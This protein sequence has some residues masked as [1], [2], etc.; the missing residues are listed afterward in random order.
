[1]SVSLL[2]VNVLVALLWTNHE[3]HQAARDWYKSH[4]RAGWATCP[5]TQAGFVRVSS[6]PRVVADAPLPAK[7][8]EILKAN[9]NDPTHHFWKD[10]IPFVDAVALFRDRFTGHQQTADAYLFGLAIHKRGILVTF[11]TSIA[12]LAPEG[13]SYL[14]SL[15]FIGT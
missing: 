10:E 6:N 4:Q 14:K 8:I 2:D 7:A 5:L 3:H 11:D 9:L 12:A 13:S 1:V 15:Q